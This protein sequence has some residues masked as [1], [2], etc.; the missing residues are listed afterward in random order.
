MENMEECCSWPLICDLAVYPSCDTL[1]M[2]EADPPPLTYR[3]TRHGHE[4]SDPQPSMASS[5]PQMAAAAATPEKKPPR[6]LFDLPSDFF[7][8]YALHRTHPALAPSP[9]EPSEPSRPAPVPSQQQ[10]TPPEAAG[11]RWTC[12][13]CGA[14]FESLQEQRDHFKSD[15]HRLNVTILTLPASPDIASSFEYRNT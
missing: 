2:T 15:L 3:R 1:W 9:E 10:Q 6:S 12:N 7:D 4:T 13:T 5:S 8:S 11:F 14:E